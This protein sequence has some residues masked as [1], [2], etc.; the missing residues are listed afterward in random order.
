MAKDDLYMNA[1]EK[2]HMANP[3]ASAAVSS[4]PETPPAPSTPAELVPQS[5]G[6]KLDQDKTSEQDQMAV[7]GHQGTKEFH[8]GTLGH[9][10]VVVGGFCGMF[11][12]FG[13]RAGE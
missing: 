1:S 8:E 7:A 11:A 3:G 10:T 5:Q 12:S 6:E 2:Q 9:Y 13:W 4:D